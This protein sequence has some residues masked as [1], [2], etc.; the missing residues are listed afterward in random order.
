MILGFISF[1]FRDTKSEYFFNLAWK[2]FTF[3][4]NRI[5]K[6]GQHCIKVK[7]FV[8]KQKDENEDTSLF[9][10]SNNISYFILYIVTLILFNSK[11]WYYHFHTLS[12]HFSLFFFITHTHTQV[13]RNLKFHG[14][15]MAVNWRKWKRNYGSMITVRLS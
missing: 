7:I 2:H 6:K 5:S 12:Q 1:F 8:N 10:G 9:W 4:L 14:I 13:F 11:I 3:F 15:L